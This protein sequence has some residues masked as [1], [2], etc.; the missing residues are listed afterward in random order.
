MSLAKLDLAA[1]KMSGTQLAQ[2]SRIGIPTVARRQL[3]G[4]EVDSRLMTVLTILAARY[5]VHIVAFGDSGP[6]TDVAPFRSVDLAGSNLKAMRAIL[7]AQQFPFRVA[8]ST[9]L[10]R[11]GQPVL[12]IDFAAPSTFGLLGSGAGNPG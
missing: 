3:A 1:R 10:A 2:S 7:L 6:V 8:H 5:P 4:G 12:H 9:F 11:A